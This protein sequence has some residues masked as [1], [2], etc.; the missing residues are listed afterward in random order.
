MNSDELKNL[1]QAIRDQ[2]AKAVV[3]QA[4]TIHLM[5]VSLFCGGHILL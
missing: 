1:A 2:V 5:L 3:G 4:D